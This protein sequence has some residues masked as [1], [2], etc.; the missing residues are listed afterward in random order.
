MKVC[1]LCSTPVANSRTYCSNDCKFRDPEYNSSR[2]RRRSSHK[3]AFQCSQCTWQSNDID[4]VS[5]AILKHF[6]NVHAY[7]HA[8]FESEFPHIKISARRQHKNSHAASDMACAIC[9][10]RMNKIT[11]THAKKHNITVQEYKE[12]YGPK[13]VSLSTRR[14][15]S[16]ASFETQLQHI[17]EGTRLGDSILPLFTP[18]EYTGV[19][20]RTQY[21]FKCK[22]C[23]FE[24]EDH[25][26]DG[27]I[28]RCRA[29]SPPKDFSP[30]GKAQTEI[31]EFIS[32]IYTGTILRNDRKVI[33]PK[34]L[35]IVL[36]DIK[37]AIEYHGLF[38][39]SERYVPR[40]YHSEKLDLATAAG[41]RLIQVFEDEWQTKKDIVKSKLH[42]ILNTRIGVVYAKHT[43]IRPVSFKECREFLEHNHLQGPDVHFSAY[44][45]YHSDTLVAVMTFSK[46]RVALGHAPAAP[47]VE[48]SRFCV[49]AGMNVIGGFSRLLAHFKKTHGACTLVSYA[50]LRY[51]DP[52]NNVYTKTGFKLVSKTP[53]G[54][55]YFN[56]GY[57]RLHRFNLTKKVLSEK[58]GATGT[59]EY[60][61][62]KSVG[63]D[64]I[65]DCGH[66]KY[67]LTIP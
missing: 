39:H 3:K 20:G 5:G 37:L 29:C 62:A 19:E 42:S 52:R 14:K 59:N 1:K 66:L 16:K 54:Y 56:N 46:P 41:Y 31:Y 51:V 22:T 34:E 67:E 13:T 26:D 30:S 35:D 6:V 48:L 2:G 32:E 33:S 7:T 44:G 50:D 53:I 25:L 45:L 55:W 4:N 61:M 9:G 40:Q 49:R 38:W 11:N 64:R 10:V 65:W 36:P 21:R 60:E 47:H 23:F 15:Q 8:Q 24:F 58:Y 57:R 12:R 43:A 18:T 27:N 17:F 28:P 63:F